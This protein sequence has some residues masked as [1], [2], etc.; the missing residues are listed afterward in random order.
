VTLRTHGTAVVQVDGSVRYTPANTAMVGEDNFTYL[1][2]TSR[3]S[4]AATVTV[5]TTQ[6]PGGPTPMP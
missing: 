2:T 6:P 4:N 1:I 5:L 3:P